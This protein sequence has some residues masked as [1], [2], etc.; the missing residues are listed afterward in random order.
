MGRCRF[1]VR[2]PSAILT[3]CSI[4]CRDGGRGTSRPRAG[5]DPL[6]R[7]TWPRQIVVLE[8]QNIFLPGN[9][10]RR[11]RT[12]RALGQPLPR[13]GCVFVPVLDARVLLFPA[14]S[15]D[16]AQGGVTSECVVVVLAHGKRFEGPLP[17][18]PF[19]FFLSFLTRGQEWVPDSRAAELR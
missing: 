15:S 14:G 9:T 11:V 1:I 18:S 16:S 10:D 2:A 12:F 13:R 7:F 6:L 17:L 8:V 4:Q 3:L 5:R 19:L